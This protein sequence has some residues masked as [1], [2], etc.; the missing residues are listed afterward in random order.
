MLHL[1]IE[2]PR[3]K[4]SML[5]VLMQMTG[6]SIMY[7]FLL[8]IWLLQL[9]MVISF[10]NHSTESLCALY[11]GLSIML[12]MICSISFSVK[13]ILVAFQV[14]ALNLVKLRWFHF[15]SL[16][17]CWN[18]FPFTS[19]KVLQSLFINGTNPSSTK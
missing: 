16:R 10:Q 1:Q 13:I 9:D 19:M 8:E 4:T 15:L 5:T 18:S 2:R 3:W 7:F 14:I 6:H 17:D 12:H 11:V